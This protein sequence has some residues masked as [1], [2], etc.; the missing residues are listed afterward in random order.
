MYGKFDIIRIFSFPFYVLTFF[1]FFISFW[2]SPFPFISFS[3]ISSFYLFLTLLLSSFFILIFLF[4]QVFIPPSP[5][6]NLFP[7]A[8]LQELRRRVCKTVSYATVSVSFSILLLPSFSPF[9]S[10]SLEHLVSRFSSFLL[11]PFNH[12]LSLFLC[13]SRPLS[14]SLSLSVFLSLS[15]SNSLHLSVL[16]YTHCKDLGNEVGPPPL[17]LPS[18]VLRSAS[19][20][21]LSRRR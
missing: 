9:L 2:F 17:I 6:P 12:F 21:P 19:S 20:L 11:T 14:L 3:H 10:F 7:S 15:P 1:S 4:L 18:T 8:W 16:L 13:Y 5:S